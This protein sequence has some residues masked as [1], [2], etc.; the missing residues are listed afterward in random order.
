MDFIRKNILSKNEPLFIT[1]L[2]EFK[3]R[4]A[5]LN[6]SNPA[7]LS[8]ETYLPEEHD[9]ILMRLVIEQGFDSLDHIEECENGHPLYNK[10]LTT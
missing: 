1:F 9:V 4:V 6:E 10:G 8:C 5:A 2:E 3:S 7:Y